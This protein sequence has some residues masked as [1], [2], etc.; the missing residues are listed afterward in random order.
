MFSKL[1]GL[2][3][4]KHTRNTS[5][6]GYD[7]GRSRLRVSYT[8]VAWSMLRLAVHTAPHRAMPSLHARLFLHSLV[9]LL[10]GRVP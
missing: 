5:V 3:T 8:T 1:G 4:E 9:V 7:N 10:A 2:I 6:W